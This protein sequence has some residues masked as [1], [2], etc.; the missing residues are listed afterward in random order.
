[1]ANPAAPAPQWVNSALSWG[2]EMVGFCSLAVSVQEFVDG[3]A[4]VDASEAHTSLV[5]AT[6]IGMGA[7]NGWRTA[8]VAPL[9][10]ANAIS[11]LN[12]IVSKQLVPLA[13]RTDYTNPE[14]FA[15]TADEWT[16]SAVEICNRI[17]D[18]E[19]MIQR[20]LTEMLSGVGDSFKMGA[21]RAIL[22][23]RLKKAGLVIVT[24][25][26]GAVL[27]GLARRNT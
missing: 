15:R 16:V 17:G 22:T 11:A 24:I 7:A 14:A 3:E 2:R 21:A 26:F 25:I 20:H 1:M 10:V 13:G 4:N 5:D 19:E 27:V 18:V 6:R 12:E 9:D 8:G 23:G